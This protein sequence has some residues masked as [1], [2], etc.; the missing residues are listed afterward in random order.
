MQTTQIQ[1]SISS[2]AYL[3]PFLD[4]KGILRC[5]G[6]API[7]NKQGVPADNKGVE[8]LFKD[9]KLKIN[10]N[11]NRSNKVS[12][13]KRRNWERS[14]FIRQQMNELDLTDKQSDYLLKYDKNICGCGSKALYRE[15]LGGKEL[16]FI[17]AHTCDHKLCEICNTLSQRRLRRK[18]RI[19]F[20]K[21]PYLYK[22]QLIRSKRKLIRVVTLSTLNKM[23]QKAD[24]SEH[25]S[26]IGKVA[27]DVMHLTLTV[28]HYK[29]TGFRGFNMYYDQIIELYGKMRK[30]KPWNDLVYG[31]EY[32]VETT[33]TP[34]GLN[35][36]IHSLLLVEQCEQNRNK[37]HKLI[38]EEWNSRTINPYCQREEFSDEVKKKIQKSNKLIAQDKDFFDKIDPKGATIIGLEN[39]YNKGAGGK[40]E[41]VRSS[42]F[43]SDK[44]MAAT[45]E[46]LSYH[47][48]PQCLNKKD[49]TL[50]MDL[51]LEVM[52][53]IEGKQLYRKFGCLHKESSL[54]I[55][56]PKGEDKL[57]EDFLESGQD[58][59][60]H[61]TTLQPVGREEYQFFI[62]NSAAVWHNSSDNNKPLIS[63]TA[64]KMYL[65]DARD[66]LDAIDQMMR[67]ALQKMYKEKPPKEMTVQVQTDAVTAMVAKY[68][69]QILYD[70]LKRR[71]ELP[72]GYE[73]VGFT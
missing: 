71:N 37:L 6:E 23:K 59:V 10:C 8:Q 39:I 68:K 64:K 57:Q 16:E 32:G 1:G 25:Y 34:N 13:G 47:F 12:S 7:G 66:T 5:N 27:Y 62:A 28:P 19:F 58:E 50:D 54:N 29:E 9:R 4:N 45:T 67:Y 11:Y 24:F 36:H 53:A 69:P 65:H 35:I 72:H 41:Q 38:F 30:I 56:P 44:M 2:T 17:G 3:K 40:K 33:K 46:A 73:P 61:P 60:V 51:L 42:E 26:V 70:D 52:P 49:G 22:I 21:N 43:G 31:G 48:T 63:K 18:Y 15:H 55:K 14:E 20:T